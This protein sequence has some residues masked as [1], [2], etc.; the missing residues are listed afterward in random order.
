MI[1]YLKGFYFGSHTTFRFSHI[2]N[3]NHKFLLKSGR[4]CT[5]GSPKF[6]NITNEEQG[7]FLQLI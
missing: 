5:T 3:K 7:E 6:H 4:L 2:S 1:Y